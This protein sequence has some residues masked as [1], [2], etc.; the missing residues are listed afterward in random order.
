MEGVVY[1]LSP[2]YSESCEAKWGRSGKRLGY[3]GYLQGAEKERGPVY[4]TCFK[5]QLSCLELQGAF[6]DTLLL[7]PMELYYTHLTY[8]ATLFY[9]LQSIL[10]PL[11]RFGL[12]HLLAHAT[13]TFSPP[14][15]SL[16]GLCFV[17]CPLRAT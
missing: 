9:P 15:P 2:P 13:A 14:L 7:T 5:A 3:I 17:T 11:Q 8:L 6:D 1:G 16:Q 12:L 10:Q 4:L